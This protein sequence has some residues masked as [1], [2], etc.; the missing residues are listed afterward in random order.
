MALWWANKELKKV[1][2]V[3]ETNKL[4][5]S[6]ATMQ[7]QMQ[8]R[9]KEHVKIIEGGDSDEEE[10]TPKEEK[11]NEAPLA[12]LSDY[13]GRNDK[14]KIILKLTKVERLAPSRMPGR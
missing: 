8:Q 7:L 5:T 2:E 9:N 14:T 3:T 13:I 6:F 10:D 1:K 4:A 12:L 11:E